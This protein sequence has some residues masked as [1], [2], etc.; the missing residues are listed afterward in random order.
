MAVALV[1]ALS[2]IATVAFVAHLA[3]RHARTSLDQLLD[4]DTAMPGEVIELA[5]PSTGADRRSAA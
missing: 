2:V 3:L 4:L 1:I 5:R